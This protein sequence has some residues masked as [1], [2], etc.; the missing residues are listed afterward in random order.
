MPF[1]G[2]IE[3]NFTYGEVHRFRQQLNVLIYDYTHVA[4]TPVKT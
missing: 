4:Y 2:F 1:C 3:V